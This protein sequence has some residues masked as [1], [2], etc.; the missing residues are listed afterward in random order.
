ME[1]TQHLN[2]KAEGQEKYYTAN[3]DDNGWWFINKLTINDDGKWIYKVWLAIEGEQ[4]DTRANEIIDS[5]NSPP[6]DIIISGLEG[7]LD[8]V[9]ENDEIL[10]SHVKK[11]I[12][13]C[14]DGYCDILKSTDET[15]HKLKRL[16]TTMKK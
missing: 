8:V 13:S 10:W 16:N 3:W 12:K 11:G 4:D 1:N 5:L 15:V 9:Y 7:N 14:K 6:I 2:L